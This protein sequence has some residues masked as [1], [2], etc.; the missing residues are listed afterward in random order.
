MSVDPVT[1]FLA[2]LV[3]LAAGAALSWVVA[4]QRAR[5]EVEAAVSRGIAERAPLEATAA[6]RG[7][8]IEDL[9][10]TVAARDEAVASVTERLV[11]PHAHGEQI[12]GAD[13]VRRVGGRGLGPVPRPDVVAGVAARRARER[14]GGEEEQAVRSFVHREPH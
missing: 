9:E 1:L 7:R 3:G 6:E 2:L 8:R 14:E 10:R 11:V 4:R 5:A 12:A 13:E